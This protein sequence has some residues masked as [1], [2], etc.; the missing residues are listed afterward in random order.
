MAADENYVLPLAVTL[1]SACD[2]LGNG[3]RL[4]LYFLDGGLSEA[5]WMGLHETLTG[6]P[7]DI[8]V[9]RPD[10]ARLERLMISHHITH[11]AYYRLLAADLLPRHVDKVI[12]LDSDLFVRADLAELWQRPLD[13]QFCLAAVDIACP[14]VD[15]RV[16]SRNFRR[17]GPYMASLRPIANYRELGLDAAAEYFNSGVMVINLARW[18]DALVSEQLLDC[19]QRH[20][21]HVWCWDQY[22]LN[23]VFTR[24]W[25]RLEPRWNQGAHVFEYP[26]I[27]H[28]PIDANEFAA[29][30]DHPAI[31]HFTTEFKPWGYGSR[32]PRRDLFF[33]GLDNTAWRGWRPVR[34]P[35]RFRR[36]WQLRAIKFQ[37]Q[38]VINYRKLAALGQ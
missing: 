31:V 38:W 17:A 6:H 12:Y 5:S 8:H 14:Y 3:A 37:K 32:D 28:A 21:R 20:H 15:A 34:P 10:R 24:Q 22:A 35:F 18:R 29:M 23:V 1:K 11:V 7:I 27:R 36:W 19:L 25:G 33:E 4:E 30:R 9:I 2:S 26:D 13:G 16:G